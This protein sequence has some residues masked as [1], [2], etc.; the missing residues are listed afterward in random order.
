M[1]DKC[2]G[3]GEDIVGFATDGYCEDC[4]CPNCG[5]TL[6]TEEQRG[7]GLCDDCQQEEDMERM[8]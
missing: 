5:T 1:A 4:L 2:K 7:Q 6:D 8:E 3:C